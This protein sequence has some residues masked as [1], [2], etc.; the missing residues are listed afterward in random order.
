M[1]Q[2]CYIAG[3]ISSLPKDIYGANFNFAKDEVLK[4]GYTPISPLDLEHAPDATWEEC[5]K[6]DIKKMLECDAVYA[7]KDWHKSQGAS[8]EIHLAGLLQIAIIFQ[9]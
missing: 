9:S 3:P 1:K 8:I 4:L 2:T 6:T 7:L 5:M